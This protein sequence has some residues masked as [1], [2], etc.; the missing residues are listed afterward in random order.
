VL[1]DESRRRRVLV[2]AGLASIAAFVVLRFLNI[3]GDPSPWSVQPSATMTVLS[4]LRTTKYPPSL[5]FLLMTLGPGMLLLA[6]FDRRQTSAQHPLVIVG[7][8]PF[9][10]YVAHFW[11]AHVVIAGLSLVQYGPDAFRFLFKPLPSMGGPRAIF[12]QPF[13]YPLWVAYVVWIGI[14]LALYPACRWFADLKARR[15]DWWLSYL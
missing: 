15:R 11:L 12:P 10:Y 5:L 13:G 2:M 8:V 7:R 6:Y 14:V 3:Y 4:F 1:L 9:F